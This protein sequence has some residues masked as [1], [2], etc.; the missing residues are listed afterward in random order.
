MSSH[1]GKRSGRSQPRTTLSGFTPGQRTL[2]RRT[3]LLMQ[4][5]PTR[6]GRRLAHEV[7]EGVLEQHDIRIEENTELTPSARKAKCSTAHL[8]QISSW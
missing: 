8:T 1:L 2:A 5:V 7:R 6:A 4:E 3:L